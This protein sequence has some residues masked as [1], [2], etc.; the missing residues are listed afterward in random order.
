MHLYINQCVLLTTQGLASHICFKNLF[1]SS[2]YFLC[3][4]ERL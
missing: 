3:L 2:I 1:L 4:I